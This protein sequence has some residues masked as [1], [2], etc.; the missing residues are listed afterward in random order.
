MQFSERFRNFFR[1]RRD[2][3]GD[4]TGARPDVSSPRYGSYGLWDLPLTTAMSVSTVFCCVDL[5]SA[6]VANLPMLYKRRRGDIFVTD[7]NN[8]LSYLL[9]V[10]PDPGWSAF[11][12]RKQMVIELLLDGN[13]YIVPD[14]SPTLRGYSR[15]AICKR[16]S[17]AYDT[18][19][20]TYT[21][22]DE[23]NGIYGTYNEDEIIHIKG[24]PGNDP[25][26]GVSVLTYARRAS[27][28]AQTGDN[29]TLDRFKNGG[30][31]RGIVGNGQGVQGYGKYQDSELRKTAEDIDSRFRSGERIVALPKEVS[32]S[33]LSMSSADMQFLESRKFTVREIC[34]FFRVHPSFVFDDTSNNY[35]SAEMAN[36]AFLS[37]T[38]NPILR[39]IENEFQRKLFSPALYRSRR[40]EFD[41]M[42]LYACDL[43]SKVKY[44]AQMI[45]AGLYTVNECR[46]MEN[47]P[48]VDGG[49]KVLVSANLK[50][51]EELSG[52]NA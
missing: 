21:V 38:L 24:M 50:G 3:S 52:N 29:E 51:I 26:K 41:R 35:K 6:S 33:Q 17:V 11:N 7:D 45:G 2:A 13:A 27:N 47:R 5:L 4:E 37:N 36:V 12:F 44:Q 16:H 1:F 48:P 31:V 14:Y 46:R 22:S 19:T 25:K 32:W 40:I 15:F 43:D 8:H 20:G 30:T 23:V 18:I 49:D 9:N 39:N 28:I 10:E 42:G 34:R